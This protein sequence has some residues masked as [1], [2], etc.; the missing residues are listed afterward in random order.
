MKNTKIRTYASILTT[1]AIFASTDAFA[2]KDYDDRWYISPTATY[3][4]LDDDRMTSKSGN[5]LSLGLGKA[6]NQN[7]NLEVKAIYNRYQHQNDASANIKYQWDTFGAAV[8][9]QYYVWREKFSPYFA[10][11]AGVM[12]SEISDRNAVGLIADAGIGFSYAFSENVSLRSDVR[13]RFNDNLN[14][15]ITSGNRSRYND[16]VVNVGFVIPIG[17]KKIEEPIRKPKPV[18]R[19]NPDLD[20]DGVRNYLDQC[21][22]TKRGQAVDKKG[23]DL[24]APKPINPDLDGDGVL[25]A[26]D[27]CP[28]TPIGNIVDKKGC[29]MPIPTLKGVTFKVNSTSIESEAKAILDKVAESLKRYP[30]K[31]AIESQ[32]H[33]SSDGNA[34]L[35]KILSQKRAQSVADYLVEKGVSNKISAH[36]Y[37]EERPIAD[38]ATKEGRN[39]NRRAAIVWKK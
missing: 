9:L 7:I 16:M 3:L 29:N 14:K 10:V 11:S 8:D 17:S 35:N 18:R 27:K 26:R 6:V 34:K 21:P 20:G 15:N 33:T 5:G 28:D 1:A 22:N 39:K 37:G 30:K 19:V 31:G 25:N 12:E 2:K 13:Y 24:P 38:N 23:C 32:G 36:G 4:G